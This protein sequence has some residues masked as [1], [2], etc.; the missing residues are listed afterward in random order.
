MS[1]ATQG[2]AVMLKNGQKR[3][4]FIRDKYYKEGV[5]RGKIRLMLKDEMDHDVPYQIV[6]A[7]TK[8]GERGK[9]DT[10]PRVAQ[11]A[12]AEERAKAK[13]QRDAEAAKQKQS[14]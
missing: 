4:D 3:S 9:K 10:D 11:A 14:K 2:R 1:E 7:S 8:T 13:A 6:F 12:R 5:E